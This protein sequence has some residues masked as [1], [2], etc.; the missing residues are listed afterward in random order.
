MIRS[1][2]FPPLTSVVYP[3]A[4]QSDADVQ[5]TPWRNAPTTPLPLGVG[6]GT[7]DQVAPFQFSTNAPV[8]L[9]LPPD[10]GFGPHRPAVG[11]R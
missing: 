9:P 2:R 5:V 3:T 11:S 10:S 1:L 8:E 6:V 7:T 4:M